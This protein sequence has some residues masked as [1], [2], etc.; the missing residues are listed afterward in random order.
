M[1]LVGLWRAVRFFTKFDPSC[2]LI[3]LSLL[4]RTRSL[5]K[6]SH[7]EENGPLMFQPARKQRTIFLHVI[8]PLLTGSLI[9]IVWRSD[10]LLVFHWVSAVGLTAPIE[11]IRESAPDVFHALPDWCLFSLPDGLWAYSFVA[12]MTLIWGRISNA[13]SG[14]WICIAP[15]LGCGSEVL[16]SCHSLPGTYESTDLVAYSA[17]SVLAYCFTSKKKESSSC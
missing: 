1:S 9:Y 17:G 4:K 2:P 15:L 7:C 10:R 14:M 5:F 16:Q 12:T 8:V 6:D 11:Y 3:S 13:T